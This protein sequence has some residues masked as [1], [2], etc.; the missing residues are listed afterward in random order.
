MLHILGKTPRI[1]SAAAQG[2]LLVQGRQQLLILA[3]VRVTYG[4]NG[5]AL[6]LFGIGIL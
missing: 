4:A 5:H 6:R 3:L 2:R 1:W